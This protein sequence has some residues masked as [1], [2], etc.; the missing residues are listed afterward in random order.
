[1]SGMV[2]SAQAV[3]ALWKKKKKKKKHSKTRYSICVGHGRQCSGCVCSLE[4]EEEEEETF[5]D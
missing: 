4:E 1:M 3:Y 2:V 5:K